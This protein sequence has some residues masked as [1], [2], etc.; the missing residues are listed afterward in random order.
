MASQA[1]TGQEGSGIE[2]WVGVDDHGDGLGSDTKIRGVSPDRPL[3]HA[4]RNR[5]WITQRIAALWSA[6]W[7]NAWEPK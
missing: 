4:V 3:A 1:G 6:V 5:R 7:P 2:L